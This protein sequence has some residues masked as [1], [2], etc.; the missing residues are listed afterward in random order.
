ME[1]NMEQVATYIFLA[2]GGIMFVF[3]TLQFTAR[4]STVIN[5]SLS[6]VFLCVGYI[7]FYYGLY[8]L[9]RLSRVPWLLYS[10]IVPTFLAGPFILEYTRNLIGRPFPKGM[11]IV[12]PLL[13]VLVVLC[14]LILFR[15]YT[16]LPVS[17]LPGPNP[18]HFQ[19]PAV[20]VLNTLADLHFFLYV[21]LSDLLAIKIYKSGD[22]RFRRNFRGTV[23]FYSVCLSTFILFFFGHTLRSD[24]LLGAAVLVNGIDCIYFF[25]FSYR[26]PEYT[27]KQIRSLIGREKVPSAAGGADV[28]SILSKLRKAIEVDKIFRDSSLSLQSLST[29]LGI[30]NHQLS[31]ILHDQMGMSFRTFINRHRVDEVKRLLAENPEM[32]ILDIAFT[33]GFNSKSAFNSAFI[34]ETGKTPS[35][36]RKST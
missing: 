18:D 29:Q 32:S 19:V 22:S 20:R 5:L 28:S 12:L 36:F 24:N 6:I 14:Y 16:A 33:V 3:A 25:L 15:P 11:K 1:I 2:I 10:D 35:D 27:Q 7:W 8:R 23:I 30:Q 31:Q 26:F 9:N 4:R 17:E 21:T 34:K 13:P